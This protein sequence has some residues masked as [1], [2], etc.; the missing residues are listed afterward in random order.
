MNSI[1]DWFIPT[2]SNN[3]RAHLISNA[4]LLV[5]LVLLILANFFWGNLTNLKAQAAFSS[6]QV[7][8]LHNQERSKVGLGAL[9]F[10]S[11]LANSA[12][13]K[14]EAMLAS[15]CWSHYCPNGKSPWDF[16]ADA[17]YSYSFAGENLAEGF[18]D[19]E[20]LMQAWMNSQTHRENILKA[21]F[22][23]IGVAILNGTYQGSANNTLVVVHFGKPR[24]TAAKAQQSAGSAATP[25]PATVAPA[26]T[27]APAI[28]ITKPVN[29]SLIKE[30]KPS[31]EGTATGPLS[32]AINNEAPSGQLLPNGGIFIYVPEN[33]LQEG[34]NTISAS[35]VANPGII[36]SS[37]ITVD[38]IAPIF[39]FNKVSVDGYKQNVAN[40]LAW[41]VTY[42]ADEPLASITVI[43]EQGREIAGALAEGSVAG[44][45]NVFNFQ[46]SDQELNSN[47]TFMLKDSAGNTRQESITSEDLK[48]L[49]AAG[50]TT[51]LT[52]GIIGSANNSGIIDYLG[53][54]L[55]SPLRVA[56]LAITLFLAT[57]I[58]LDLY[59]KHK[60][61]EKGVIVTAPSTQPHISLLM[62]LLLIILM[63]NL[64]GVI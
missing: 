53:N 59:Y 16:F 10:N 38:S 49:V 51:V 21:D 2:P 44:E 4:A 39:E 8:S 6:T 25:K 41:L 48:S 19:V 62:I 33:D 63:G 12:K 27:I 20:A 1:R 37:T 35:L 11:I 17:G 50:Q 31:I 56:A 28:S 23:E 60:W 32:V 13:A 7:I 47:L 3:F 40:E 36:A 34:Q 26:A 42:Q 55:N 46:L 5:Y 43:T 18:S 61:R 58:V 14:G 54:V 30:N 52:Q 15:D 57:L 29:G 9:T 45:S 24:S 22:T 64:G